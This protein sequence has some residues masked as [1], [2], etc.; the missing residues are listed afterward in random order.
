MT[1]YNIYV[2][3]SS[4]G[5]QAYLLFV[6]LPVVAGLTQGKPFSNVYAV[7]PTTQNDGSVTQFSFTTDAFACCGTKAI[8]KN[9]VIDTNDNVPMMLS[10]GKSD[11]DV[12]NMTVVDG[13]PG[14]VASSSGS[15][16]GS[17]EIVVPA[18]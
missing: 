12:A 17:F 7:A 18:Y 16:A 9:V 11:T 2:T 3:N 14:F 6:D 15:A 13:G 4:F 1:T 10:G 8:G 5:P